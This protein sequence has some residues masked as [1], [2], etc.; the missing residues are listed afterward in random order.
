MPLT[1]ALELQSLTQDA[2][3]SCQEVQRTGI[4]KLVPPESCRS[5]PKSVRQRLW[6]RLIV[7]SFHLRF[8]LLALM[9]RSLVQHVSLPCFAQRVNEL[10]RGAKSEREESFRADYS[11][12]LRS[13]VRAPLCLHTGPSVAGIV[14][15]LRTL[16]TRLT[17]SRLRS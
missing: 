9:C 5:D 14:R 16:L 3:A 12:W 8:A 6:V 7:L 10:Q 1:E 2:L 13:K 4:A 17:H 15:T 11:A